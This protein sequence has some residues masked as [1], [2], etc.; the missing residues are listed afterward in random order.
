MWNKEEELKRYI[1]SDIVVKEEQVLQ[2]FFR[3]N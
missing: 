1:K 2:L 3:I